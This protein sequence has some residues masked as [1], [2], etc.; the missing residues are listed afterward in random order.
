MFDISTEQIV[1]ESKEAGEVTGQMYQGTFEVRK[2]LTPVQKSLADKERRDFLRNPKEGEAVDPE[3][4][5][6]AFAISQLKLRVVKAPKWFE[7][8]NGLKNFL[9]YNV[10]YEL[11]NHILAVEIDFKKSIEEK[12]QKAKEALT[13]K[14][15]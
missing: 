11:V 1:F 12:A 7:E 15:L 14:K 5:E 13:E 8:S 3:L 6:L 9:D 10:L 4:A 2:I